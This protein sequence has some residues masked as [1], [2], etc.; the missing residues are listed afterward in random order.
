MI[1]SDES[2]VAKFFT[3]MLS[4][5]VESFPPCSDNQHSVVSTDL[6]C[7]KV[8][9][10]QLVNVFQFSASVGWNSECVVLSMLLRKLAHVITLALSE[11]VEAQNID[12]LPSVSLSNAP[13]I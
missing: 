3:S 10:L 7:I 12:K 2:N 1:V 13:L 5:L 8:P 11:G 6:S 9:L 4:L